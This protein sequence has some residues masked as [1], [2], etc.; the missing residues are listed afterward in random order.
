MFPLN[1]VLFPGASVPLHIFEDR[2]RALVRDLLAIEDPAERVFGSVAIRDG[3][4]VGEHGAQSLFRVGV[5]LQLTQHEAHP[6]GTFDIVAVARDR[7]RLQR[8]TPTDG[9]PI[10]EVE[11]VP[12]TGGDVAD[13]TVM[14]ARGMFTAYRHQVGQFAVDP[15]PGTLPRDPSYLA[16]ALAAAVPLPLPERQE[17]LETDDAGDR[18]QR[19]ISLLQRELRA[20]NVLPSLPATDVARNRFSPN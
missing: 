6:D 16:W 5:R 12:E 11:D 4:E 1:T 17:L 19:L 9:C 18:L 13:E 20:L 3:Y 7:I 14:T 2:Y 8:L 15:H 10:G